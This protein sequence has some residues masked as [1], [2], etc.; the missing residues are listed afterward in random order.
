[1]RCCVVHCSIDFIGLRSPGFIHAPKLF[2]KPKSHAGLFHVSDYLPTFISMVQ[3]M[4]G[5]SQGN[6]SLAKVKLDGVNQVP[7]LLDGKSVRKSVHI[8]R[9]LLQDSH[10]YRSALS[11][12]LN[13]E[14][15]KSFSGRETGKLLSGIMNFPLF[16]RA[17]M[18]SRV[19][20][21]AGFWI[22]AASEADSWRC[23]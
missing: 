19:S 7:A 23:F 10:V 14:E 6:T 1:M 11:F 3:Q 20:M 4:S 12:S 21:A 13:R 2:K 15:Y 18:R 9:D 22:K 17:S 16:S 5:E 8:H